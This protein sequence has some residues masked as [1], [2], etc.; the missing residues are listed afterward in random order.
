MYFDVPH[1]LDFANFAN[2]I[3]IVSFN[4]LPYLFPINWPR[5]R[6][7][8]RLKFHIFLVRLV[9]TWCCRPLWSTSYLSPYF[10][11]VAFDD[12][13]LHPCISWG[14]Q[15][16]ITTGVI[17]PE[18]IKNYK[19]D[20][21]KN[22]TVALLAEILFKRCFINH[23][24]T[25][26]DLRQSMLSQVLRLSESYSLLNSLGRTHRNNISRFLAHSQ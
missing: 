6:G 14:C 17:F 10:M 15:I 5:S 13:C 8:I 24:V 1:G 3:H 12:Y 23:F 4:M 25:C 9:H 26:L 11:R 2:Y 21:L 18:S 7:L 20:D 16:G 19:Y 22:K